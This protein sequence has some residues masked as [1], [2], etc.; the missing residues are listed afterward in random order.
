[1]R[2]SAKIDR[3]NNPRLLMQYEKLSFFNEDGSEIK[4]IKKILFEGGDDDLP[5]LYVTYED[6]SGFTT[7]K[8]LP[9]SIEISANLEHK[10]CNCCSFISNP[11]R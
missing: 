10:P 6:E 5:H 1:M 9:D 3:S 4:N 8:F 2:I 11:N 7:K